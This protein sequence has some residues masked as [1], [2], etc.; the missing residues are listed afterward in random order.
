MKLRIGLFIMALL[1][2]MASRAGTAEALTVTLPCEPFR[3]LNIKD[4]YRFDYGN[5]V[6][7]THDGSQ[8][9]FDKGTALYL[10]EVDG[11]RLRQVV[12]GSSEIS[13][14][15]YLPPLRVSLSA[16]LSPDGSRI[17][18]ATCRSETGE[19]VNYEIGTSNIDGTE[20]R[21]LTRNRYFDHL[22]VWSPD[23]NRIA[24]VSDRPPSG[25]SGA[26]E[27]LYT[28]AADGSDVRNIAPSLRLDLYPPAWSPDGQRIAFV[29]YEPGGPRPAIYTVRPDGSD[30]MRISE[31]LSSPSWS[32]DGEW[33]AFTKSHDDGMGLY[34]IAADGS[35]SRLVAVV[36]GES[37][38]WSPSWS[39]SG[40]E[41]LVSCVTVCVINVADGSLVGQSPVSLHGGN[42]AAW[43]PD[44][45]RIAVLMAQQF[46]YPNGSIVL[47]TM[48]RDGADMGVLVRGGRSL[49]AENSGW[50]NV[51]A[52]IA[53]C[54]EGFVI[55][56]PER[57]PGLVRDCEILMGMR[58]TLTGENR[59]E[60]YG[61]NID[62]SFPRDDL[63]NVVLNWSPGTPMEQWT[64]VIIEDLC[65]PASSLRMGK[66]LHHVYPDL[67][68][69]A[70][71]EYLL[72]LTPPAS[73]VTGLGL[74]YQ[75]IDYTSFTGT[76]PPELGDLVH[77]RTL[78]LYGGSYE[79]PSFGLS[80]SIP[81]ELG[82]LRGLRELDLSHNRL[83]GEIPPE[84][85][86]LA[87]LLLLHLHGNQ[88]SGEIPAELGRLTNLGALSLHGNQLSGEIPPELGRLTNLGAL[89][90]YG[91]QLS[92]CVPGSLQ[93]QLDKEYS[94]LG[95]LPFCG[96]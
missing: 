83:S 54:S 26:G 29:V 95:G 35:D 20:P 57:N 50:Q 25:G 42:V 46:A 27:R 48:A 1:A 19:W 67:P 87:N 13:I 58:D 32:P 47:Y 51:D 94:N 93:G 86:S 70:F 68:E 24:F 21:R 8:I 23:G 77:L 75:G 53:S 85:G 80:G 56:E 45:S 91:N 72:I 49:V 17:V 41:I 74:G 69:W 22:P 11:S 65:S 39:P 3:P 88:F 79:Y 73:R 30:L 82:K 44:G 81:P 90:L 31:A 9:V 4:N 63:G 96:G 34:A 59:W 71:W 36:Q 61:R 2:L 15:G 16:N 12:E 14:G 40:E 28:M 66:C 43:S 5:M 6:G 33:I 62:G 55:T 18:Y 52:G 60:T 38:S 76:I 92:G 7:W 84:L 78:D 64:G 37:G 89:S 10:G